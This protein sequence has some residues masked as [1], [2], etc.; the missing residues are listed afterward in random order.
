MLE[1]I[2]CEMY[3]EKNIS[4]TERITLPPNF[5]CAIKAFRE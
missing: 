3:R 1:D 4:N 5:A 2:K